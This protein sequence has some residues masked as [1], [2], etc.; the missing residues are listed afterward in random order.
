MLA[1]VELDVVVGVTSS[2]CIIGITSDVL[3]SDSFMFVV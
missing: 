2:S 3:G 1:L